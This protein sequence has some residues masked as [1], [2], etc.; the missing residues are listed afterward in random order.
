V[1]TTLERLVGITYEPKT[2]TLELS[3]ESLDHLVFYPAEIWVI[4][5][6]RQD[7]QK[8]GVPF[9]STIEV[10]RSDATKEI[11]QLRTSA[12][13]APHYDMPSPSNG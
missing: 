5:E 10:V 1:E 9:I 2:E 12:P 6:E 13:P 7:Q 4:E 8:D 3:L 11:V